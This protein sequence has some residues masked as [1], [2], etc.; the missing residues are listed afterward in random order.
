M[1]LEYTY[2]AIETLYSVDQYSLV[3]YDWAQW[4]SLPEQNLVMSSNS[5]LQQQFFFAKNLLWHDT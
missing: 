4:K 1:H 3:T 5:G 2:P